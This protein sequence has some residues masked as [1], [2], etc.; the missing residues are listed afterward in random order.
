MN[1]IL[2]YTEDEVLFQALEDALHTDFQVLYQKTCDTNS[3]D[4]IL[5]AAKEHFSE[6]MKARTRMAE[7]F[8]DTL[9]LFLW[10][11]EDCLRFMS[12]GDLQQVDLHTIPKSKDDLLAYLSASLT[13]PDTS[14]DQLL[15]EIQLNIRKNYQEMSGSGALQV[16]YENFA[17][18]YQFVEQLAERS[19]QCV[20]TLLL[21]LRPHC[22]VTPTPEQQNQAMMTL[23]Q[24]IQMTLRK[25]DVL[26]GC[27]CT[28]MLVLLMDADD[29]GG[30]FAANRIFNTF[31]GLYEGDAYDLHYDIRPIGAALS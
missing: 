3:P 16:E 13:K 20:Q 11:E 2:I 22:G 14:D 25:N 12:A 24:A 29:D 1:S 15:S 18:I 27:S 7:Q 6:L 30:H 9:I 28:Q 21:T 10:V 4:L 17:S 26:T 8:P 19:G 31:L 23:S 5:I